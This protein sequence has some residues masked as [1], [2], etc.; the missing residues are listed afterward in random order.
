MLYQLTVNT[1]VKS[2]ERNYSLQLTIKFEMH[3]EACRA[4]GALVALFGTN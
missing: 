4:S 1:R 3:V 2:I